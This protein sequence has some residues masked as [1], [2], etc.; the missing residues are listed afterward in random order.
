MKLIKEIFTNEDGSK[1]SRRSG[2]FLCA[3][4]DKVV[5][6]RLDYGPLAKTCGCGKNDHKKTHDKCNT[7]L[8]YVWSGAKDRCYNKNSKRYKHYGG[9]G[10]IMCD[11]WLKDFE[12]FDN[13]AKLS[14]YK[15]G[16][17]IDRK[18][19]DG[20]YDPNNCRF[21]TLTNNNRN[22]QKTKLSM[23]KA[24]EIRTLYNA[25]NISQRKLAKMFDV[26]QGNIWKVLKNLAWV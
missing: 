3:K 14:G 24:N 2:T 17:Q 25:G 7:K 1:I 15:E 5:I 12:K 21:I 26:P 13:W 8:Y 20:N 18:N 19:N 6:K 22:K 16:L 4:C 23:D 10:I 11:E 9:R